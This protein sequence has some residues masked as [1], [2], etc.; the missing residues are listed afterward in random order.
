MESNEDISQHD[1]EYARRI[2]EEIHRIERPTEPIEREGEQT[3][4]GES[5][6]REPKSES[7][8]NLFWLIATGE[9]LL[10]KRITRYYWQLLIIAVLALLS[11]IVMFRS[12]HLDV[13]HEALSHEVQLL[14]ERSVRLHESYAR[15]STL[16]S[17]ERELKERGIEMQRAES[18]T[19]VIKRTN[20]FWR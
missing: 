7:K 14:Q 18:P 13:R 1:E 16:T 11:I 9:I 4:G 19:T 12:L 8:P 5:E 6:P 2:E 20:Q 17:I 15:R 10:S 3:Q